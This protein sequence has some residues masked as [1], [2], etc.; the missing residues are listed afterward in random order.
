VWPSAASSP[1][2]SARPGF[3]LG[4]RA[5]SLAA[6]QKEA[7]RFFQDQAPRSW[8]PAYLDQRGFRAAERRDWGVGYAPGTWTAVT[9]YLRSLGFADDT[10]V[11]SGLCSRSSKKTV[12]DVFRDR[13]VLPVRVPDGTAVGFIGRAAPGAGS[14]VPKYLNSR[15]NEIYDKGRLLFGLHEGLEALAVGAVP[16]IV[17]G[18]FDAMAVTTAGAGRYVGVAPCGTAFTP[19]QLGTLMTA[20]DLR[21]TGVIT[22][23]DADPAGQKAAV[24]AYDLLKGVT[25]RPMSITFADGQDP[26]GILAENGPEAL[27]LSLD[28]LARPLADTVVG[29]RLFKYRKT[30]DTIDDQYAVLAGVAPL[31]ARMPPAEWP[32]QAIR[33][34]ARIGITPEDVTDAVINA[35]PS[36]QAA[37]DG[38]AR[39]HAVA[40]AAKDIAVQA[41]GRTHHDQGRE[42]LLP[43]GP[44]KPAIRRD[45]AG[46]KAL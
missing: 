22:A 14:D 41:E 4:E 33:V 32:R 24:R 12:I 29:E 2:T 23:F 36:E 15:Q 9:D 45:P 46:R 6:V 17:E 28:H 43:D 8:V 39:R 35:M 19:E 31:I 26:A 5:R 10:L 11:A 25:A 16:V 20:C 1:S 27:R 7:L 21:T 37:R 40:L 38:P 13:A 42:Q 44:G 3:V 34:A 18:P 30:L